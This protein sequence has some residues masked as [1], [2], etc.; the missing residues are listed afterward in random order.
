M[1]DRQDWR[2][3][4]PSAVRVAQQRREWVEWLKRY[5]AENFYDAFVEIAQDARSKCIY[6]QQP[7]YLD[8]VMGGGIPDWYS[9]YGDFGCPDAPDTDEEGTGSH[10]P[11]KYQP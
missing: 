4:G 1:R 7:I 10:K 5:G 11:Q 3:R 9:H 6:C 8:I 2:P